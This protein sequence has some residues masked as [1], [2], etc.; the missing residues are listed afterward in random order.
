M[1]RRVSA[2]LLATGS[3]AL[4]SRLP[5][6]ASLRFVGLFPFFKAAHILRG[7]VDVKASRV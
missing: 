5:H 1:T 6:S 4:S 3:P 2:I 7:Y